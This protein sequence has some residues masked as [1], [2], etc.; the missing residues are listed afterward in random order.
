MLSEERINELA[1][2]LRVKDGD[3]HGVTA[4]TRA[5]EAAVLPEGW[6]AVPKS[7]DWFFMFLKEW[8]HFKGMGNHWTAKFYEQLIATAP[9]PA[10]CNCQQGQVCPVCDPD[11]V[12]AQASPLDLMECLQDRPVEPSKVVQGKCV[13]QAKKQ[14]P[15][16]EVGFGWLQDADKFGRGTKL[17]TH[18]Q[19]DLTVEVERLREELKIY[20]DA[21]AKAA[22]QI[23]QQT[24]RIAA[25][26]EAARQA[27]DA[28]LKY[29]QRQS[30]DDLEYAGYAG[31]DAIAKLDAVLANAE[32]TGG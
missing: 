24:Q 5:I 26:E 15:V 31:D 11:L 8:D 23:H 12:P 1:N 17:Y 29:R 14:E 6:V 19:P 22:A 32:I 10:Q 13:T 28:L 18:P 20:H 25:L 3:I 7:P 4:F 16:F 2:T 30:S 21:D 27:L 9:K